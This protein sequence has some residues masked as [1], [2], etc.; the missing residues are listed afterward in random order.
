MAQIQAPF[1]ADQ[2]K[3]LNGYQRSKVMHPFT[4][5]MHS[6]LNLIAREDGWVCPQC[7]YRQNWAHDWMANWK[8]IEQ[9]NAV[10]NMFRIANITP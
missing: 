7:T 10:D 6:D 3:S 8:W 5:A 2:V 9:K 1:T 4:C